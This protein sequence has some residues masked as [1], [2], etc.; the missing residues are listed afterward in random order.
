MQT[1]PITFS[2]TQTTLQRVNTPS[3]HR[4]KSLQRAP[5]SPPATMDNPYEQQQTA[6]ISRIINNVVLSPPRTTTT[7]SLLT[8]GKTQ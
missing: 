2:Q 8:V 1:E 4:P 5:P 7:M 3:T 6:L